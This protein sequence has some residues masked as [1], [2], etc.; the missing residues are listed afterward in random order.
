MSAWL[1]NLASCL[2]AIGAGFVGM[3]L[4]VNPL[5]VRVPME[6]AGG[7]TYL[8]S[9]MVG[10]G[11]FTITTVGLNLVLAQRFASGTGILLGGGFVGISV[12]LAFALVGGVV[13]EPAI[14][15]IPLAIGSV[16][17][18]RILKIRQHLQARR[19][20]LMQT[21]AVTI[22]LGAIGMLVASRTDAGMLSTLLFSAGMILGSLC[23]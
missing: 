18:F 14:L 9:I 6:H 16:I 19:K 4:F 17:C 8:F 3:V 5:F 1:A 21:G 2:V 7:V 13:F 20:L 23:T 22:A 15:A 10:L 11:L 12:V